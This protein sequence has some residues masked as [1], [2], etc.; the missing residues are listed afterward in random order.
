MVVVVVKWLRFVDSLG[1]WC[2]SVLDGLMHGWCIN[3]RWFVVHILMTEET[4]VG[5]D[6]QHTEQYDELKTKL[7]MNSS[8]SISFTL[9]NNILS[10]R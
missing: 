3:G 10:I 4:S 8:V 5:G 6:S 9:Q 1:N 2:S 7:F